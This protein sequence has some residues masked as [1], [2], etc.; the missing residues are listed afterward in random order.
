MQEKKRNSVVDLVK[1]IAIISVFCA[2][3]NSVFEGCNKFE[4]ISSL[5]LRNIGTWGVVCFFFISGA[6]FNIKQIEL[7]GFAPYFMNKVRR[8]IVPWLIG[9]TVIYMYVY[10]RH[11]P[12]SFWSWIKF[13]FGYD[14]YFYYFSVLILFYFM[15]GAL[16]F[17][18]K[19]VV[20]L[21][22][23]IIGYISCARGIKIFSLPNALNVFNWIGYFSLG[24]LA[25][26]N[27]DY[28]EKTIKKINDRKMIVYIVTLFVLVLQVIYR[29][30]GGYW[31]GTNVL[32]TNIGALCIISIAYDIY[33]KEFENKLL[34][35]LGRNSLF[36]YI[37]HMPIASITAGVFN[38]LFH[39]PFV[40]VRPVII[41]VVMVAI[42]CFI[43]YVFRSKKTIVIKR[44][45]G[46]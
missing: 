10:L 18:R 7:K 24:L 43:Q 15:F 32:T 36:V 22:L 41:T 8:I 12:L 1:G 46:L 13:M 16:S 25:H 27:V 9:S 39:M 17:L 19:K 29:N 45:I 20:L 28:F 3:S 14:S 2:H 42:V 35:L 23:V 21:I 30:P 44:W 11:P 31:I 6:L 26:Q 33:N 40:L 37:W 5:L 38:N 34:A 4:Q